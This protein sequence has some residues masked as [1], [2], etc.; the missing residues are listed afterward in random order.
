[1]SNQ[2]SGFDTKLV[3]SGDIDDAF[4]SAVTPIYQTSTFKFKDADNGADLFA[5]REEGFIYS[6]IGN[7][8]V[9]ALEKKLADIEN[10]YRCVAFASGMAAVSTAFTALLSA[11]D[12]VI[13]TEALYGA[14]RVLLEK[15]FTKFGV[16]ATFTDTSNLDNIKNAIQENTKLLYLE[17]PANPT[18]QLTD[19][20]LASEIAHQHN[21]LVCVDNTFCSPLLQRPLDLGADIVLHSLTKSINGHADVVAGAL[22]SKNKIL[23]DCLRKTMILLGGN[24]DPNQAYLVIRGVKTLSLRVKQ[25]QENA[26]KV[27]KFLE[28]H[29]KVAWVNY[30]GLKSFAQYDLAKKQMMG[31]GSMIAFGVKG[32]LAA[33]KTVMNNVQ[34]AMLAVSLGGI[35]TLIQHPASMTHA[36]VSETDRLSAGITDDLIRYAIGIENVEDIIADIDNAL[37]CIT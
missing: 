8:T 22:I 3:H 20:A 1:M 2:F 27:A 32:G 16:Q 25:A 19:I 14:S 12:H 30:P 31:A 26:Q 9:D 4:G 23:D 21:I 35:E 13:C 17:T 7:P 15:I 34:L 11:D 10:G 24:I 29:P 6:R 33:G 18:M 36:G 37:N 28:T 5:G